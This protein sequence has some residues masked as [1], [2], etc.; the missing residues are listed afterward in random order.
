MWQLPHCPV[1]ASCVCV[2]LVGVQAVTLWQLK[3]LAEPVGT[4]VPLRPVALLPLWQLTQLVLL[5]KLPW[6]T[7]APLQVLVLLWQLSQLP[8]TLACAVV[9]GLPVAAR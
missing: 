4:C 7:L 6:S 8:V 1:T 9:P 2:H 3:Q 5:L